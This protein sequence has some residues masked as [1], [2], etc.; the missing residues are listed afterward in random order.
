MMVIVMSLALLSGC[1]SDKA[2]DVSEEVTTVAEVKVTE[3]IASA[4]EVPE[5]PEEEATEEPEEETTADEAVEETA[6]EAPSRRCSR[7][8]LRRSWN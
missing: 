4:D 1:Q 7:G 3:D 8:T 5:E 6:E 2:K